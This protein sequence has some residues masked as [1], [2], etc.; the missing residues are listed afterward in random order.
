MVRRVKRVD[1]F[2]VLSLVVIIVGFN[3]LLATDGES[4]LTDSLT[5]SFTF[6]KSFSSSNL[7][8]GAAVGVQDGINLQ[9]NIGVQANCGDGVGACNCADQ[10]VADY[11]LTGNL[12]CT[13]TGL[14]FN[15]HNVVLDCAGYSIVGDGGAP[16]IGILNNG[17]WVNNT[18]KNCVIENFGVGIQFEH[19]TNGT[20]WNNTVGHISL[21]APDGGIFFANSS[22]SNISDNIITNITNDNIDHPYGITYVEAPTSSLINS[23]ISGNNISG[24]YGAD[25]INSIGILIGDP[26]II[27]LHGLEISN[28][29]ITEINCTS[30]GANCGLF[31]GGVGIV[32]RSGTDVNIT[33]NNITSS[34]WGMVPNYPS[35]RITRNYFNA[36]LVGIATLY[37]GSTAQ[38]NHSLVENNTFDSM[39]AGG[40]VLLDPVFNNTFLNN[41]FTGNV[42]DIIGDS[43]EVNYLI[44]NNSFG[45]IKWDALTNMTFSGGLALGT[46]LLIGDNIAAF[47]SSGFEKLNGSANITLNSL[48]YI[49]ITE[50]Y[51]VNN[52]ST[53]SN[54]I[55]TTGTDCNGTSCSTL[56][57]TSN[58]L[59][60]NTSNFSSFSANG[61]FDE[62]PVVTLNFPAVSNVTESPGPVDFTF[63]CSATD[64]IQLAN[65][66][67][68][69]TNTANASFALNQSTVISGITN[70]T[71]WTLT[72]DVGDYTW[73]CLASDNISNSSFA[74]SNR[75]ISLSSPPPPPL[76]DAPNVTQPVITPT[77]AF[78]N[79][80][81]TANTTYNDTGGASSA[82]VYFLWYV[83]NTN[84][85][86]QTNTSVANGTTVIT[87]LTST[88]FNKSDLV[89]VSV[90]ANNSS[91]VSDTL[92]STVLVIGNLVPEASSVNISSSDS[93]NRSNGTLTGTFTYTDTDNDLQASNETEWYN[94]STK[95]DNL[96][97]FTSIASG[98]LSKSDV[99]IFS[100]RVNDSTDFSSW[101]NSSAITLAANFAPV[102]DQNLTNQ[103]VEFGT[104]FNADVNCSDSDG[105][106]ITYYDNTSLFNINSSNGYINDTSTISELGNYTI[107]ISCD[108]GSVNT[109]QTFIYS[110][111]DTTVPA[112]LITAVAPNN[113]SVVDFNLTTNENATCQYKNN[114]NSLAN[115]NETGNITHFQN[116]TNLSAGDHQYNFSCTDNSSNTATA[117][118]DFVVTSTTTLNQSTI[119][120]NLTGNV[121]STINVISGVNLT[122]NVSTTLGENTSVSVAE[123]N[124]TPLTTNFSVTG[125]TVTEYKY[126]VIDAPS[127]TGSI[128]WITLK[129]TYNETEVVAAGIAEADLGIFFYNATSF[130]WQEET[131]VVNTDL[132]YIE[133][134]VTHLS[135]FVLGK[136]TATAAT[137]AAAAASS[138]S[139]STGAN[140]WGLCGDGLCNNGL[141]CASDVNTNNDN[142]A[143]YKDCGLCPEKEEIVEEVVKEVKE[144]IVEET[145]VAEESTIIDTVAEALVGKAWAG[146]KTVLLDLTW[147]WIGLIILF[148]IG[149]LGAYT[150]H[151]SI[152]RTERKK[153]KINF[154]ENVKH[155]ESNFKVFFNK[156][157]E[158]FKV[159]FKVLLVII[160]LT[161]L[162]L[163]AYLIYP[164]FAG[165][166]DQEV[167]VE[168]EATVIEKSA[169]VES[170]VVKGA[171]TEEETVTSKFAHALSGKAWA[172]YKTV[173][174]DLTWLWIGL[175]ILFVIGWFGAY[176][177]HKSILRT[178]KKKVKINFGENVRHLESNFKVFFNKHKETFLVIFKILIII[179]ALFLLALVAYFIYSYFSS[180]AFNFDI[181]S[182]GTI[183]AFIKTLGQN[184]LGLGIWLVPITIL[185]ISVISLVGF[186]FYK[187][188]K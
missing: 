169:M 182:F 40:M 125:S 66:S 29:L 71:N 1:L 93:L 86:N 52:Y 96:D 26:N 75:S 36:N 23:V 45:E 152:I 172:G 58:T 144:E 73:N 49:N 102:F 162:G 164:Y 77:T 126:F 131:S 85:F 95:I 43:L 54:K 11:N 103:S 135:T 120:L 149:W 78:T 92:W 167:V 140:A 183:I 118:L 9:G 90:Y 175:I 35:L 94:G 174:L 15:D 69:I 166:S 98:N 177:H 141:T 108:D 142:G 53:S 147:L 112:I 60:F 111:V 155:L 64:D 6:I 161:G 91:N 136:S 62:P 143:C 159:I 154:G 20:I 33:N 121:S 99:W 59:L 106:T 83:N 153:V 137:A 127:I 82:T 38:F 113:G 104:A 55:L 132:N 30:F 133:A 19:A 178:E 184:I 109:S 187:K 186:H 180:E 3:F 163:A 17:G 34:G 48:N 134:N 116:V 14:Q 63:N 150:H 160:I 7:L 65:I 145:I 122:F 148:V 107:N 8:T 188:N 39:L 13:G 56:S 5:D 119:S 2:V 130:T 110:I 57:Y 146:Y 76:G 124:E 18:V 10:M 81:L 25:A 31:G 151:K 170:E 156:H 24:I 41:N 165:E 61:T 42:Q 88:Y 68:Y 115:M 129:F 123:Y 97:N 138:S 105:E 22:G 185:L 101:V 79:D 80:T 171:V 16:D 139:S 37:Q 46:N 84:I 100:V 47:N 70:T 12:A 50:I 117:T 173:F 157:K 67:L 168:E 72:L 179:V 114:S 181:F 176:T 21:N 44:Y 28:N 27:D 74:T 51:R 32:I 89:N 158:I 87:T 4:S 128:N